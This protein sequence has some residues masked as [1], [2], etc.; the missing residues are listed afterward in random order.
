MLLISF[1]GCTSSPWRVTAWLAISEEAVSAHWAEWSQ[2][3]HRQEKLCTAKNSKGA[4]ESLAKDVGQDAAGLSSKT[5]SIFMLLQDE[6]IRCSDVVPE[7]NSG[8]ELER[9][10]IQ[11]VD[12]SWGIREILAGA[13]RSPLSQLQVIKWKHPVHT[14]IICWPFVI[15]R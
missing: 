10:W 9:W 2:P 7:L 11:K 6:A 5:N 4:P 1:W 8:L 14:Q 12:H 13:E 15:N 3:N